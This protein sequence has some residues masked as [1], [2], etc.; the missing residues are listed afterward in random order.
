MPIYEYRCKQC[1]HQDSD[2][3]SINSPRVKKCPQCGKRS[4]SR[5]VSAAAFHLKGGGWYET[6]F[7]NKKAADKTGKDG[8]GGKDGK[9]GKDGKDNK[10]GKK[11]AAKTEG[12]KKGAAEKPEKSKSKPAKSGG[13]KKSGG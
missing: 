2:M 3:D 1:G 8:G 13:G 7:K 4:F 9:E 6:D 11:D 10:D 12:A 5:L